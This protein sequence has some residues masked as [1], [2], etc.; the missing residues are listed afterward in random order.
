MGT[1]QKQF[2]VGGM[3]CSFCAE[4]IKKAYSRTDGVEDIDVSLAHEEVLV[5]YDDDRLS[6]IEVKDTLRDLG[7]TIRDPDKA[8]R[9]KQQQAELADGKRRLLLAGSA[10]IVVAA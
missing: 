2:N 10:S 6:E 7:Y 9:Y 3:S 8:K 1:T 4:S 5:Q